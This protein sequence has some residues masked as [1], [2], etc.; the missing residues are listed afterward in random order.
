[1]RTSFTP[2]VQPEAQTYDDE[3]GLDDLSDLEDDDE[4]EGNGQDDSQPRNQRESDT[5]KNLLQV[6][7]QQK[8]MFDGVIRQNAML[9]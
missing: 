1:L 9:M 3:S 6:L 2:S 5:I 8:E 7:Q 4:G